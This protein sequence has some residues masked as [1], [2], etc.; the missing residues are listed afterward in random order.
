VVSPKLID[1]A[2]EIPERY[3]VISTFD[4]VHEAIDPPGLL[5][6]IKRGL[7]PDGTYLMLE[8]RCADDP[9]ENVG[10]FFTWL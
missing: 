3:D 4:V 9:A 10:P 2:S 1:A 6:S 5:H 7:E 8:M